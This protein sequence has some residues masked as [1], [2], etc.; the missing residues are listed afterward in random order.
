[1]QLRE[2]PLKFLSIVFSCTR[3]SFRMRKLLHNKGKKKPLCY[4]GEK[5]GY[6]FKYVFAN[7]LLQALSA[8]TTS[9]MQEECR[10]DL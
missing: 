2:N 6:E 3:K 9:S 10:W 5:A 1:M 8:H 4:E 7:F